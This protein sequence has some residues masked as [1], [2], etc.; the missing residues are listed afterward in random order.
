MSR[1]KH[2][3]NPGTFVRLE[4]CREKHSKLDLALFGP[5]GRGGMV[6]DVGEVKNTLTNIQKT[7]SEKKLE[8]KEERHTLRN[9]FLG[10][11]SGAIIALIGYVLGHG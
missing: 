5:D 2:K 4:D 8:E 1:R 11:A 6:K 3:D 9:W 7:L 10:L